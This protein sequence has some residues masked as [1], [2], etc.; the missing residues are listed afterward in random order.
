ESR[1]NDAIALDLP[2]LDPAAIRELKTRLDGLPQG[3]SPSVALR[4]CEE[5]TLD[6]FI[7]KVKAAQDNERLLALSTSIALLAAKPEEIEQARRTGGQALLD[8]CGGT[9]ASLLQRAEAA[10]P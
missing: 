2:K 6:W 3:G 4:A 1:M 8:Q 5:K 7:S 9:A 10:R